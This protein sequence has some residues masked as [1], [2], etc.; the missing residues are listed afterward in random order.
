MILDSRNI[1]YM[2]IFAGVPRRGSVK[3]QR[4]CRFRFVGLYILYIY[5]A[6]PLPY[7]GPYLCLWGFAG[8]PRYPIS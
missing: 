5:A 6:N 3:R 4:G 8:D 2:R 7:L 1:R